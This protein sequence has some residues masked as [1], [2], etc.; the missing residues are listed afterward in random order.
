MQ[1]LCNIAFRPNNTVHSGTTAKALQ[2]QPALVNKLA[3]N[4]G[5]DDSL[6]SLMDHCL[7]NGEEW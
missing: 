3:G 2:G 4:L 6:A 7:E 1:S 5:I